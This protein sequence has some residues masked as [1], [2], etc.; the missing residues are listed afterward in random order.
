VALPP[1][2]LSLSLL[3]VILTPLFVRSSSGLLSRKPGEIEEEPDGQRQ[4]IFQA[5]RHPKSA[6]GIKPIRSA[7]AN[8]ANQMGFGDCSIRNIPLAL[9]R[10]L[11]NHRACIPIARATRRNPT[12]PPKIKQGD[13]TKTI[14]II[15]VTALPSPEYERKG[16][17]SGCDAY[18]PKPIT[19]GKFVRLI[20]S[21]LNI[22]PVTPTTF[23]SI[24]DSKARSSSAPT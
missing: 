16:L 3:D 7:T 24:S 21:F 11:G 10:G 14:P 22:R 23:A 12:Q 5:P 1:P 13:R 19:L 15:A 9:G 17:E 20:E 8:P 2:K 4:R 6:I 18:I